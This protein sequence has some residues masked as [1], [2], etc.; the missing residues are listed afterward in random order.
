MRVGKERLESIPWMAKS[1]WLKIFNDWIPLN[2]SKWLW[3]SIHIANY[4]HYRGRR[5]WWSLSGNDPTSIPPALP[6]FSLIPFKMVVSSSLKTQTLPPCDRTFSFHCLVLEKPQHSMNMPWGWHSS[7]TAIEAQW[8]Y[9]LLLLWNCLVFLCFRVSPDKLLSSAADALRRNA[10][11]LYGLSSMGYEQT[12]LY[13]DALPG[14]S[15][16]LI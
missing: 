4:F 12:S 9:G 8:W 2:S 10:R 14:A 6:S 1:W 16:D 5:I 11:P 13:L 3:M 7:I 15:E